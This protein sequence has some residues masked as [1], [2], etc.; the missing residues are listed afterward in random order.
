LKIKASSALLSV[1]TLAVLLGSSAIF[2]NISIK[3]A[4]AY[5]SQA[6]SLAN[7]CGNGE[8]PFNILCQNLA[9]EIQ[10]DENAINIMG[11]QTGGDLP[12]PIVKVATLNVIK[13]VVCPQFFICP[14]PGGFTINVA[15]GDPITVISFPASPMGTAVS[16]D[17]GPYEVTEPG[18]PVTP[19]GLI[20]LDPVFSSDC[21]GDIQAGQELTCTITN[22][23][24]VQI[25]E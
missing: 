22:E 19:P 6:E 18:A 10:G 12:T 7:A 23:Y 1:I 24:V 21:N 17:P 20:A 16:L 13:E 2:A 3:P 4:F 5:E 14:A 11:L 9:S 15:Y 25:T 8:L